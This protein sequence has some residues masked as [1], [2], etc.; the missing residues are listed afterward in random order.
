M[1]RILTL[2]EYQ[3]GLGMHKQMFHLFFFNNLLF[4]N[5]LSLNYYFFSFKTD[6][7]F[8]IFVIFCQKKEI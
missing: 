4:L 7:N 8:F 6:S 5:F 2:S 3:D 1:D